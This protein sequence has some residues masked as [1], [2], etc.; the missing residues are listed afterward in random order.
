[1]LRKPVLQRL[2]LLLLR[3]V[4]WLMAEQWVRFVCGKNAARALIAEAA[5]NSD[6]APVGERPPPGPSPPR[7]RAP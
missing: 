4:P 3:P 7:R 1:L 2:L 6:P 5:F